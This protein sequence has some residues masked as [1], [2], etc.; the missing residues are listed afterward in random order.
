MAFKTDAQK[1]LAFLGAPLRT[2]AHESYCESVN[3]PVQAIH[4][5]GRGAQIRAE[6][7]IVNYPS[8]CPCQ[9]DIYSFISR[10]AKLTSFM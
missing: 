2:K 8:L 6:I 9:K 3:S 4:S 1:K 7:K 5:K 10:V